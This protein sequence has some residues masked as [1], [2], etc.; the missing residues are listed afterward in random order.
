MIPNSATTRSQESIL[1]YSW[2]VEFDERKPPTDDAA[3]YGVTRCP[4]SKN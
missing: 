3:L 1:N 2:P 4:L